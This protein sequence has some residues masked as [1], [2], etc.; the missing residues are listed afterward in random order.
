MDGV[1]VFWWFVEWF[2][3]GSFDDLVVRGLIVL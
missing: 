2:G 1:E 3:E